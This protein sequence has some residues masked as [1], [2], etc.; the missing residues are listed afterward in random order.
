MARPASFAGGPR[1]RGRPVKG[2][3]ERKERHM[4]AIEKINREMQKAPDDLYREILGHYVIDRCG[5][6]AAARLVLQ[7]GKTLEGA[8]QAATAAAKNAAENNVAVVTPAQVFGEVDR[9]F[10]LSTDL[11]AQQKAVMSAAAGNCP[12]QTREPAGKKLALALED[13]M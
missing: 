9:Y 4:D 13:F 2:R 3:R 10:G 5:D 1:G 11:A 7:E 6:A 8:M 12:V